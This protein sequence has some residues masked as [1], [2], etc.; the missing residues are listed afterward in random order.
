M[1]TSRIGSVLLGQSKTEVK[2]ILTIGGGLCLVLTAVSVVY[3]LLLERVLRGWPTV[4]EKSM[5]AFGSVE[6]AHADLTWI[7]YV[8]LVSF[9]LAASSVAALRRRGVLTSLAVAIAPFLGY[10]VGATI[11]YSTF[12]YSNYVIGSPVVLLVPIGLGVLYG[13]SVGVLGYLLGRIIAMLARI[14]SR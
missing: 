8:G 1:G 9:G 5:L 11:Y 7:V 12:P 14:V 13:F 10:M 3:H 2:T 4:T 6:I